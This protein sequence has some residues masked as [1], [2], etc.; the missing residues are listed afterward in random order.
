M[1]V[2]RGRGCEGDG[3]EEEMRGRGGHVVVSTGGE[4]V[5]GHGVEVGLMDV[6]GSKGGEEEGARRGEDKERNE[7]VVGVKFLSVGGG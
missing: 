5:E 3:D 6:D 2:G 4:A 1:V 7:G